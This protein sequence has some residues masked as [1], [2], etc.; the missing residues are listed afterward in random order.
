MK[1]YDLPTK[2]MPGGTI[3]LPPTLVQ[4][5]PAGQSIRV[6]ILVDEAEDQQDASAW[7]RITAEQFLA[8]YSPADAVYDRM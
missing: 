7:S 1:A 2:V 5:L 8:G 3:H 4:A 6:I